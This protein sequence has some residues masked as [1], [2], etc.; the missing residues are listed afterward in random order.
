MKK[1]LFNPFEKYDGRALLAIGLVATL[2]GSMLGYAFNA[3][4]DG[5]IDMHFT[6]NVPFA[7]PFTDN[8]FNIAILFFTLH[9]YGFTIN[10]KTRPADIL[11][12]IMLARLPFY[13][14]TLF[15]INGFIARTTEA[16][17]GLDMHNIKLNPADLVIIIITGL[18][19]LALLVWYIALLYN[20]FKTATNLKTT[21]QKV[22][23]AVTIIVAEILSKLLFILIY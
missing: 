9:L 23:F 22:L 12:T 20:G 2:I 5:A 18:V 13:L 7:Q 11:G 14:G 1:L 16:L 3:R 15:N 19:S 4:F 21:N 17:V 10:K 8:I 6:Y